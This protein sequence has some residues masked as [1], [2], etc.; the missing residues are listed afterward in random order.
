MTNAPKWRKKHREGGYRKSG[1]FE[2]RTTGGAKFSH[3]Q[4]SIL[5]M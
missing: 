4:N 3:R 2:P 1:T 5:K